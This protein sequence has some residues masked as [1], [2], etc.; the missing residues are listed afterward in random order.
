MDTDEIYVDGTP[1]QA[2]HIRALRDNCAQYSR[3]N[4][5]LRED[6]ARLQFL[7]WYRHTYAETPLTAEEADHIRAHTSKPASV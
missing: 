5:K 7:L 2:R 1:Y 6:K 3:E 4:A